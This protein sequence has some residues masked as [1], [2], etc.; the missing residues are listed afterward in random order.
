MVGDH[1]KRAHTGLLDQ[2]LAE[3]EELLAE[4]EE[5]HVVVLEPLRVLLAK[6]LAV[7]EVVIVNKLADE[8]ALPLSVFARI[9][10]V[11]RIW[12]GGQNMAGCRSQR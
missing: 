11:A 6:R 8:I 3:A 1:T 10:G 9:G 7:H 2:I 4:A 12:R 5:L